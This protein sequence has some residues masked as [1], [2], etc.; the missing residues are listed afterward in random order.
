M[1]DAEVDVTLPKPLQ[2]GRVGGSR[3]ATTVAPPEPPSTEG[4]GKYGTSSAVAVD[5]VVERVVAIIGIV[6]S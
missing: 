3:A 5:A 6:V 1:R 2:V 4:G